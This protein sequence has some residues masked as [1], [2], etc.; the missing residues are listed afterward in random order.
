L[1]VAITSLA[2]LSAVLSRSNRW[3]LAASAS[4][5]ICWVFSELHLVLERLALGAHRE[6]ALLGRVDGLALALDQRALGLQDRDVVD[7][8]V[9]GALRGRPDASAGAEVRGELALRRGRHH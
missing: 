9:L 5:C 6:Q 3:L 7:V 4:T 2:W 8:A 1:T